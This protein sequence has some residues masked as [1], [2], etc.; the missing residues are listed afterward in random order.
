MAQ[1]SSGQVG[2]VFHP[3]PVQDLLPARS[4]KYKGRCTVSKPMRPKI[5]RRNLRGSS[6]LK[7]SSAQFSGLLHQSPPPILLPTPRAVHQTISTFQGLSARPSFTPLTLHLVLATQGSTPLSRC[8]E[9]ASGGPTWPGMW[10]G[11]CRVAQTAPSSEVP[12]IFQP[13]NFIHYP[14]PTI[15]GHT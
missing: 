6:L 8:Y 9:T 15:P 4:N 11:S 14:N 7:S 3:F 1:S 12:V 5:A 2:T 10:E 13:V